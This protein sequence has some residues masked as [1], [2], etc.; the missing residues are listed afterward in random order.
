MAGNVAPAFIV[1]LVTAVGDVLWS[2]TLDTVVVPVA[3]LLKVTGVHW[4]LS[5]DLWLPEEGDFVSLLLFW[6]YCQVRSGGNYE[7]NAN[8]PHFCTS[9]A[10]QLLQ[11]LWVCQG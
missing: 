7:W 9:L 6:L 10:A 5:R 2:L 1:E 4:S 3:L 11:K 8:D